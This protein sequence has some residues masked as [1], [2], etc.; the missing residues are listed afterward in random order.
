MQLLGTALL[1]SLLAP[2][3]PSSTWIVDANN[4]PGTDF[5]QISA[6]IAAA[7]PG[8]TLLVLPGQYAS[9]VLDKPLAIVGQGTAPA[10]EALFTGATVRNLPANT[11]TSLVNLYQNGIGFGGLKLLNAAGAVLL[12]DVQCIDPVRI[13]NCADARLRRC[14]TRDGCFANGSRVEVADSLL[15]G[16]T[17]SLC[18]CCFYPHAAGTGGSALHVS[19]GEVHLARSTALGGT[20]GSNNCGDTGCDGDA[21]DGG[22]AVYLSAGG[23]LH[24]AG[25]PDQFLQGG[26]GGTTNC[27][28][29]LPGNPGP[30]LFINAGCEARISGVTIS[31]SIQNLG[32]LVQPSPD[33]PTLRALGAPVPGG[34]FTL[35]LSG[36]PGATAQILL[37]RRP[38]VVPTP[39]LD[40]EQLAPVNRTFNLGTIPASGTV[41]LNFPVAVSWPKG[42]GVVFQG[43]VTLPDTTQLLTNSVPAVLE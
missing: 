26:N 20:G 33:D 27:L 10:N 5:T 41:S 12:D 15:F 30:A 32:T 43:R 4:G 3:A 14:E 2:L 35:R 25:S 7:A 38:I 29:G 18:T 28:S 23:R 13:E 31:G 9:F 39:A 21:G 19:G 1:V 8:D 17:G 34:N 37:G 11:T 22:P 6:A 42:F 24:V 40:E 36:P 16:A